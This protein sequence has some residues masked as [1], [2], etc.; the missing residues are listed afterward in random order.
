[1]TEVDKVIVFLTLVTRRKCL[2]RLCYGFTRNINT[3]EA[4]VGRIS[5]SGGGGGGGGHTL[6]STTAAHVYKRV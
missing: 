5:G 2:T 4:R 6:V 1:M 3:Q